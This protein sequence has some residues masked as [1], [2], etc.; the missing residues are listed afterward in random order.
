MVGGGT[1]KTAFDTQTHMHNPCTRRTMWKWTW[2]W[3][4]GV[5]FNVVGHGINVAKTKKGTQEGV[6]VFVGAMRTM[7]NQSTQW[8]AQQSTRQ[9]VH[10]CLR[11]TFT[12]QSI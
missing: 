11:K 1:G 9:I 10:S 7:A 4:G 6:V 3:W 2:I 5:Q 8:T 12:N